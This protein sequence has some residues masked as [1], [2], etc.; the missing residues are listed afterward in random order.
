MELP[1]TIYSKVSD[2]SLTNCD[3]VPCNINALIV[4]KSQFFYAS[5]A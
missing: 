1:N 3:L 2:Y 4:N 5:K